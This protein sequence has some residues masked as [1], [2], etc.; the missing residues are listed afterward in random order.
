MKKITT[1]IQASQD[2]ANPFDGTIPALIV[3]HW[4]HNDMFGLLIDGKTYWFRKDEFG[5][6]VQN[7]CNH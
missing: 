4:N 7:A 3:S 6:A 5:K 2:Q 1:E